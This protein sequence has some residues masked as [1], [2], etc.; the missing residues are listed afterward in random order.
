MTIC[1]NTKYSDKIIIFVVSIIFAYICDRFC[2]PVSC[3]V[4]DKMSVLLKINIKSN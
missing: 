2:L 3:H 1:K 4:A